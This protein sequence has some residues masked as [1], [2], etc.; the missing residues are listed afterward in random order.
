MPVKSSRIYLY[1]PW[2]A[3]GGFPRESRGMIIAS[4]SVANAPADLSSCQ[5]GA[6]AE[7]YSRGL[8]VRGHP[9]GKN[10][11]VACPFRSWP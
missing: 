8:Y 5:K 9:S 6:K 3:M 11:D 1:A 4:E 10:N 2:R 7:L